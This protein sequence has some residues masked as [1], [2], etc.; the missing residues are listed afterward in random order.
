MLIWFNWCR[1]SCTSEAADLKC[2]SLLK[3]NLE[4]SYM[5]I[6][7]MYIC[8]SSSSSSAPLSLSVILITLRI[9]AGSLRTDWDETVTDQLTLVSFCLLIKRRNNHIYCDLLQW[10]IKT[11][12]IAIILWNVHTSDQPTVRVLYESLNFELRLHLMLMNTCM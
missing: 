3:C 2:K 11:Q 5:Y 12:Q 6:Q 9:T 7:Y 1:V 4:F 10:Y 8:T